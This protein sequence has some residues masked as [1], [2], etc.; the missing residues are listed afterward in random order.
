M[1]LIMIVLMIFGFGGDLGKIRSMSMTV[2]YA[3]V[4]FPLRCTHR[5]RQWQSMFD[6][7]GAG[8]G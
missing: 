4:A 7:S 8:A 6:G 3:A 5:S 1:L 2:G